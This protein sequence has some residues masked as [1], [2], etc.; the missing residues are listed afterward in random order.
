MLRLLGYDTLY[1]SNKT[2]AELL[3]IARSED[4]T[5][6]TRGKTALRFPHAKKIIVIESDYPPEQ[7]GQLVRQLQLDVRSGLWTRCTLCNAPISRVE[8]PSV[9]TLVKPKIF[10]LYDQF[11]RCTGCGHIYWRGSHVD[12]ILKNMEFILSSSGQSN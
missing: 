4:R 5:I 10:M 2:P 3:A 11:Y 12:R 6:L 8:K 1:A 9:G 7:F